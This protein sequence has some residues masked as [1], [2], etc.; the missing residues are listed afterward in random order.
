MTLINQD[1]HQTYHDVQ[2]YLIRQVP[3]LLMVS[4]HVEREAVSVVEAVRVRV[5]GEGT[6]A[7]CSKDASQGDFGGLDDSQ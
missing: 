4:V 1:L 5:G 6:I 7:V 3:W 2:E